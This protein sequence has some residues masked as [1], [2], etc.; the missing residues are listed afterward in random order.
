MKYFLATLFLYF[1]IFGSATVTA[2]CNYE[3]QRGKA[4]SYLPRNYFFTHT[5]KCNPVS[6]KQGVKA[7]YLMFKN[8]TYCFTASSK[9]G[10]AQG[11]VVTVYDDKQNVICSNYNENE[12]RFYRKML[13]QCN[14]SGLYTVEV[15][16]K[17]AKATCGYL[18]VGV[19]Y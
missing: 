10:E 15:S 7:T 5:L 2:Q 14:K 9:E 18:A 6:N 16:F 19:K 3:F 13:F 17:D 1:G 11:M 12:N 4:L 8:K